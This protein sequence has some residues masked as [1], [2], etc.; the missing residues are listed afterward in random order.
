M[1]G[2]DT[3]ALP[4]SVVPQDTVNI[5]VTLTGPATAASYKG[6]WKFKNDKGVVFGLVPFGNILLG[7]QKAFWVT[8]N[9]SGTTV[10]KALTLTTTANPVIYNLAGQMI[11]FTYVIKN[12]GNVTLGPVQFTASDSLIG[13][14]SINCGAATLTLDPSATATCTATYTTT[15]ANLT[16]DSIASNATASGGGAGPSPSASAT[17][18]KQ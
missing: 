6:N 10:T 9:V 8:I 18:T 7:N 3:A 5:S 4:I 14:T 1:G 15:N 17:V 16:V 12:T 13:A 2:L 11:T